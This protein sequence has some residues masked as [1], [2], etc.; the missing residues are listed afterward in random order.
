MELRLYIRVRKRPIVTFWDAAR[1]PD[2]LIG[3]AAATIPMVAA[4]L[5]TYNPFHQFCFRRMQ[6]IEC[7]ASRCQITVQ[8]LLS[9]GDRCCATWQP[10]GWWP[11]ARPPTFSE[12]SHPT[13]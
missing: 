1:Q 4:L 7:R 5:G 10:Q 13:T 8:K 12:Q 9:T 3:D 2:R 6:P 11:L